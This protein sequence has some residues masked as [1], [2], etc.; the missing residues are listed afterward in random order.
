MEIKEVDSKKITWRGLYTSKHNPI[1]KKLRSMKIGTAVL[2]KLDKPI[3]HFS[4]V[5]GSNIR[6]QGADFRLI[7]ARQDNAGLIWAVMKLK[8]DK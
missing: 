4:A 2:I 1:Y 8:K 6:R 3:S 5:I 7:T